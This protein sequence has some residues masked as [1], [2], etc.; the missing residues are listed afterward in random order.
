MEL[1]ALEDRLILKVIEEDAEEK[2]AS[3]FLMLPGS[4]EN[5]FEA[6]VLAVGKGHRLSNGKELPVDFKV[7]DRVIYNPLAVQTVTYEDKDYIVSFMKDILAIVE[8][9]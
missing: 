9:D 4:K 8:T 6:E 5:N 7:G 3:G 1:K 2:T